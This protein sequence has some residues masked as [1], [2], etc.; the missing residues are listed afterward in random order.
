VSRSGRANGCGH[1]TGKPNHEM[2][3]TTLRN[4]AQNPR[5]STQAS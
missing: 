2:H 4:F 3:C 1:S 5:N